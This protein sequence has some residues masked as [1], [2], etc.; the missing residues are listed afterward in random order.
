MAQEVFARFTCK[1]PVVFDTTAGYRDGG[2]D[3]D[4][5]D[6]HCDGGAEGDG[7]GGGYGGVG[8]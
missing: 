1:A 8:C 5:D 2:D 6:G 3:G 4:G 7:E